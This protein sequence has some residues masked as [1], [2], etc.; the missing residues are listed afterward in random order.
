M[1]WGKGER[2]EAVRGF[3]DG[4][5]TSKC[6]A[7]IKNNVGSAY[8]FQVAE[9]IEENV[10]PM[11]WRTI[12]EVEKFLPNDATVTQAECTV[13]VKAAKAICCLA[14]RGCISSDL[15]GN[16]IEDYNESKTRK[17]G[18][19]EDDFEGRWKWKGHISIL[20]TSSSTSR[21]VDM[22]SDS[23]EETPHPT[24][25]CD[26]C[27][28]RMDQRHSKLGAKPKW[29]AHADWSTQSGDEASTIPP[30]RNQSLWLI[31]TTKT[32]EG[33]ADQPKYEVKQH[34]ETLLK[35]HAIEYT[36]L[37]KEYGDWKVAGNEKNKEFEAKR[38]DGRIRLKK[39]FFLS[40]NRKEEPVPV[41]K[42]LKRKLKEERKRS[43]YHKENKA[44]LSHRYLVS[45]ETG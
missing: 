8:V 35:K 14:R 42:K 32:V 43:R 28:A 19:M 23:A 12:I 20:S 2:V 5:V 18:E 16:L 41:D 45:N 29:C 24:G 15:D 3:L 7:P 4:G 9:R 40:K 6:K 31:T 27:L 26:S 37:I 30:W 38:K 25:Y 39:F 21:Q 44:P 22:F 11:E 34:H 10:H 13:A 33:L 1:R 36:K 17:R